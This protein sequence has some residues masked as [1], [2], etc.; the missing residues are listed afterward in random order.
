MEKVKFGIIGCGTIAR[1]HATAIERIPDAELFGV[2]DGWRPGAERFITEYPAHIFESLEE[3]LSCE[4]IDVVCICTPSGL[5]TEQAVAAMKAG[6]NVVVEKPMSLSL[7]DADLLIKT[8]EETGAKVCVI[9]QFRFSAAVQEVRRALDAGA[10]GKVVSGSLSMKY[11]RSH[12]YYASGGWR[13]TWAMDGGGCLMNQGIHGIDVFRYLMGEVKSITA[14]TKTQTRKIEVEDSAAAI[15]E[16]KNG[17]VGTIQGST[18]CYPGYPR[19]IEIC[20]EEGS[21]VMEE[22]SI[23]SWDLPIECNLPVGEG[24]KNVASSD[25]KAIDVSGHVRQIANLVD[26]VKNGTELMAPA[27]TGRPPLEVILGIYESSA[28]GARVEFE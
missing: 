16:F 7:A 13:G 15:L 11:F 26:A 10:F 20:G 2:Y 8:A 3:M 12:E 6:K 27:T 25:P 23:L 19:R 1:F 17:A 18:T 9:S 24:A 21:V 28:K 14:I 22:D 5:H 4:N